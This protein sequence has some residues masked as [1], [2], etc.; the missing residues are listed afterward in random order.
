MDVEPVD[1]EPVDVAPVD[2]APADVAPVDVVPV[3]DVLR[4]EQEFVDFV[5]RSHPGITDGIRETAKFEDE[6]GA[7]AAYDEFL[8]QFETSEGG[9]IK[10]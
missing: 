6:E 2:V 4:F 9:S 7:A 5:K 8:G 10:G 1:V 3:E